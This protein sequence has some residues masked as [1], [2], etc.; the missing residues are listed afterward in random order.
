MSTPPRDSGDLDL[1]G[2]RG[3]MDAALVVD[4]GTRHAGDR[5]DLLVGDG[6]HGVGVAAAV[7]DRDRR[8]PNGG[9]IETYDLV[10]AA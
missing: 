10:A 3:E 2:H 4:L 5:D 7:V 1:S 8:R 6:R 9:G